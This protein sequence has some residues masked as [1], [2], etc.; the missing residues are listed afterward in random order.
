MLESIAIGQEWD[1]DVRVVLFVVLREG[2]TL[3]ELLTA[4]IRKTIRDRELRPA[5]YRPGLIRV[6]A[7]PRTHQVRQDC[8]LA[9][10]EVVHNRR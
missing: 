3:D 1:N 6:A 9:V 7:I 8:G 4:R 10:R 5:M 2:Y